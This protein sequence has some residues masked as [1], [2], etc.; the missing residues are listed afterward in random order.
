MTRFKDLARVQAAIKHNNESE[1]RWALNYC[2]M[3]LSIAARKEHIKHCKKIE[4]EVLQA[5]QNSN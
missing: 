3:R 1:P 2:K 4:K 5:L